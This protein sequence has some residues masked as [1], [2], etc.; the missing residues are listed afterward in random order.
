LPPT[1]W[2]R[3]TA[4]VVAWRTE[5][6]QKDAPFIDADAAY[7]M[8]S[9]MPLPMMARVVLTPDLPS[10]IKRDLAL[11]VWTRAVLL[12]DPATAKSMA[13][14]LAPFFP[15]FADNWSA[16]RHATDLAGQKV[17]ASLLLLKLPAARPYP[18]F[19]LGYQY[20][21][22]VIGRFG[23]RWW[24]K[25]DT[26]FA[27]TDDNGAPLLCIDCGL[28]LSLVAPPFSTESE[29]SRAKADNERLSQLPGSSTW[30]GG[31]VIAWARA[32]LTDPRVPEAL[33]NVV[34]A[35]QYGD[36]DSDTSKAAYELLHS[37]FP[38]NSWTAKT[39][40]WF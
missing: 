19:G 32:H 22:D 30:L 16:Y 17:E 14:I 21:R 27:D 29:K 37:K 7:A 23:P 2:D 1:K 5:L 24:A 3:Y 36:M 34:R 8:S 12:D 28:P 33:H 40:L 35:T 6:T 13:D 9:F 25:E 20:K 39:P 31:I 11:A 18:D 10:N 26:P 38:R 15:Q 4:T